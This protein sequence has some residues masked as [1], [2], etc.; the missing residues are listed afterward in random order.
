M[1][2]EL[3]QHIQLLE[4]IRRIVANMFPIT[5]KNG[6]TLTVSNL[7]WSDAG[8][9]IMDNITAHKDAKLRERSVDSKL[10]ADVELKDATGTVLDSRKNYFIL[11]MPHITSRNSY[12]VDGNEVQI[13]NQLRL[14]P[15]VYTTIKAGDIVESYLNTTAAGT[16]K[17][18]LDR[19]SGI[20][21][22]KV[23]TDKKVPIYSV[24]LALGALPGDM[25]G[26]FGDLLEANEKAAHIE[27][28]TQK[29]LLALWPYAKNGS[30]VENQLE[31]RKF[32]ESKPLDPA[33]NRLTLGQSGIDRIDKS[34][35]IAA[36]R[37]C[38]DISKG[39]AE[40]DDIESLAFKSI[41]SIEDFIPERLRRKETV[42]KRIIAY[43]MTRKATIPAVLPSAL[44]DNN[45]KDF[46]TTSEFTRFSDQNN[47]IDMNA[48]ASTTTIMG[49]GGIQSTRA[50]SDAVRAVHTSHFGVI[51]PVHTPEG[52]KIGITGH[53]SLGAEKIG[54]TLYLTVFD[55]ETGDKK[56]MSVEELM[57]YTVAFADQYT[58][59]GNG[60]PKLKDKY[61]VVK[62][63]KNTKLLEVDPSEVDYIFNDPATFFSSST[64]VIPFVNSNSANRV[65]MGDKHI[66]Q[67]VQLAD[68]D[69]PLVL[70]R[71]S[72]VNKGYLELLGENF[73]VKSP[74]AG[75]VTKVTEDTIFIKEDKGKTHAVAIHNNYPLNSKTFLHDDPIVTV[76]EKVKEGQALVRNNFTKDKT[77]ALGK[78]LLVAMVP[79]K[80]YNFEDGTVISYKAAQKLASV[81]KNEYRV[82]KE[83]GVTVGLAQY[84]ARYPQS[85]DKFRQGFRSNY[86]ENGIIKKGVTVHKNDILI[87]AAKEVS[88]S[89]TDLVNLHKKLLSTAYSDISEVWTKDVPGEVVDVINERGFV[90]VIVRSV[91][92]A[93]VGDKLSAFAGAKGIITKIL[94]PD[95]VYKDEKGNEIDVLFNFLGTLGRANP[96]FVL[97]AAAGKVAQKTG[98]PFY[99]D[100]FNMTHESNLAHVQ[101]ELKKA[102]ITDAETIVNPVT[103]HKME[104][105]LVGPLH[106]L[107]LKHM[108][109]HKFS[110]RGAVGLPYT[111]LEQPKK[112]SGESA[113][114]IAPLDMSSLLSMGATAFLSDAYGIK[115]QKNDDYWLALQTG[116]TL[117]APQTPYV[118]NKFVTMML[119]AGINLNQT[120][121]KLTATPMTDAEILRI[122][123]GEIKEP[124]TL[125]ASSFQP[126]KSGLFDEDTTGGIG[127]NK[128]SHIRLAEPI[129]NPLMVEAVVS[130]GDFKSGVEVDQ[131]LNGT[132]SVTP[133]GLVIDG[134]SGLTGIDGIRAV[135]KSVDIAKAI[136]KTGDA[137]R[138]AK[139]SAL[140]KLNRRLRYLRALQSM[141]LR[142]EDAY[143]NQYIPV[144]PPKFRQI[145][146]RTD[147]SVSVADANHAYRELLIIN[148]QLEELKNIGVDKKHTAAL[149]DALYHSASALVGLGDFVTK[150]REY[151]G[152]LEEING[153]KES[154]YGFFKSKLQSRP[155]DLSARSTVIPNPK[156]D[157]DHIGIPTNMALT[158][159]TPFVIKR[160][161]QNG[162]A[163]LNARKMV[164]E[165]SPEAVRALEVEMEDRPVLMTRAPSL[166]KFNMLSFKPTLI[167]GK[168]VEVNPLIVG[169]YN[170][171][172]DGNCISKSSLLCLLLSWNSAIIPHTCGEKATEDII[173]LIKMK[174]TE[175]TRVT[176]LGQDGVAVTCTIV[177]IPHD[178]ESGEPC[179][180]GSTMY[181]VPDGISVLSYDYVNNTST[182][183]PV[184]HFVVDKV[185][186]VCKVETSKG[187]FVEASDNE[188]LCVYDHATG[189]VQKVSPKEAIGKLCPV[190]SRRPSTGAAGSFDFGWA[191]GAFAGDG[192]VHKN[193][194]HFTNIDEDVLQH[195]RTI[196][197]SAE[198]KQTLAGLTGLPVE[199]MHVV[200]HKSYE[201]KKDDHANKLG[202]SKKDHFFLS[203]TMAE[204]FATFY[205]EERRTADKAADIEKRSAIYKQV[206]VWVVGLS[207]EALFGFICGMLDTDGT[208]NVSNKL[209]HGKP[210]T[211]YN[212]NL[213][214]SSPSLVEGLKEIGLR[215]GIAMT[216]T[217]TR[218]KAGRLQK[219]ESYILPLSKCDLIRERENLHLIHPEREKNLRSFFKTSVSPFKETDRVP[220]P[221][222]LTHALRPALRTMRATYTVSINKR[223][224]NP[225]VGRNTAAALIADTDTTKLDENTL[226]VFNAW[227]ALVN[228]TTI[229]WDSVETVVY[230]EDQLVYDL[231]V[232]STKIFAVNN[233]LVVYDTAGI[234]VPVSEEARREAVEKLMPS[235]NLISVRHESAMHTPGKETALGIY[236][237]TN[238]KGEP[239]AV[240]SLDEAV[241]QHARG[242]LKVNAAIRVGDKVTCVGQKLVADVFPVSMRP[243]LMVVDGDLL[244]QLCLKAARTLP[245]HV[246]GTIISKLKDLGNHYVTEVGAGISLKDLEFDYEKR[247]AVLDKLRKRAPIVGFDAAVEEAGK[248]LDAL[249]AAATDNRFVEA[250]VTSKATSKGGMVRQMIV[251]PLAIT[252]SKGA[253]IPLVINKSY[254]E[255]QDLGSYLGTT[256]GAR[257][258]LV[259]K[260]ISVADTGYLSK[261]LV[262]A[263]AT[264]KI[265]VEDCGTTDGL[266]FDIDDKEALNR[267][268]AK[269][270]IRN[271]IITPEV[272]RKLK[273]AGEKQILA[274]SPLKCRALSGM[275]VKCAGVNEYGVPYK[276][277][278]N[279]GITAAQA[280]G[281]R[282]TQVTLQKFHSGG[283]V[284]GNVVGFGRIKQLLH[285]PQTMSDKAVLSEETG[286]VQAIAPSPTGGWFVTINGTQHFVAQELGLK[287]KQ[288]DT[289]VAG[290]QISLRGMVQPHELLET[291]G[292][293]GL[294]Q[295]KI[296]DDLKGAY[297]KQKIHRRIFETVVKPMTDK[298][299]VVHPGDADKLFNVYAGD[300]LLSSVIDDYNNKLVAKGLRPIKSETSL[301][302]IVAI[303]F[304]DPDFV[305][306]LTHE[307]LKDTLKSAPALNQVVDIQG[308]HPV[309]RLVLKNF[310]HVDDIKNAPRRRLF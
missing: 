7:K 296:V 222:G 87:P 90:K 239:V 101:E 135:L 306:R 208:V 29:L 106:T 233:G 183:E 297:G 184:T 20:I 309:S 240:R 269:D 145:S 301:M 206:P 150:G 210:V 88:L 134:D 15:G 271:A 186:K 304:Q 91:E 31:A 176:A 270:P 291:T 189:A 73:L 188:S 195:F 116:R 303:P 299:K 209:K 289:V 144:I 227:V 103:G 85:L 205:D 113:Q 192:S 110:A 99:V 119:G 154:K 256:P 9:H 247:D 261:L 42:V 86:D 17:L 166:H 249:L 14:R 182:Y 13:I 216:A 76:G 175:N 171:D 198:F 61:K 69:K 81:H 32:L 187:Y 213:C 128:F 217:V 25:P 169:G 165:Q 126:M 273:A 4:E 45:I 163:P 67:S 300:I 65:L 283:A 108:V 279:V 264:N 286:V 201:E 60:I 41:H 26:I 200:Y 68:P 114:R 265:T 47:P 243:E 121:A 39:V 10:T 62:A 310:G 272:V 250:G 212:I 70:H 255:G 295:N 258:G 36:I 229:S 34:A 71:L 223:I 149:S 219:W 129:I 74:V 174:F 89:K 77:L 238:P 118:A 281:E 100:N 246:A 203:S 120:G 178:K 190:V 19:R 160:L 277:G 275:C 274:R 139:G 242:N 132:K 24:L 197:Q 221:S 27:P 162:Y 199:E 98:K 224:P 168:A 260:G 142:P 252:D 80:G 155:Q 55:R 251:T 21:R 288:G 147:G 66:E 276:I 211:E 97:E 79:Y 40:E 230:I 28:D 259:D 220:V 44:F 84:I 94:G 268:G 170:M 298:A 107:K 96:G 148:G 158:I 111:T 143:I 307:R 136:E 159:Y 287:I 50:V 151:R 5:A 305:G 253:T 196:T 234:H 105:V 82:E 226:T 12:I 284:G 125:R 78:N 104:N 22:L 180:D 3:Q 153:V 232:P 257:Q 236:L 140:N 179:A 228:D 102:G 1:S 6:S 30:L 245:P 58:N 293:I 43:Q 46:M 181:P 53:L 130:V 248:E 16:Y 262:N 124:H 127:G 92:P 202:D 294:V 254:A 280:I 131:I 2:K 164:K 218:P 302:G 75:T 267:F 54:N 173:A 215:L 156:L 93:V 18:L 64:S 123:H 117:P 63:R 161:V 282:A 278:D 51:D 23:G 237:M 141:N 292:D 231:I 122:S 241:A 167:N 235:Q 137:A 214:T 48:V 56:R 172:F 11:S 290:Q 37:R 109:E 83:D 191:L 266:V 138:N 204:A 33:V 72:K 146:E 177:D 8:K 112:E 133:G 57:P 157:M 35:V 49:E 193:L 52:P 285:L 38:I 152:L 225:W 207:N 95:E 59:V 244:N 194:L 185:H 263:N 308:D 115:S